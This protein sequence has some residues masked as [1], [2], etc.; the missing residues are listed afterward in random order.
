MAGKKLIYQ[1]PVTGF[2]IDRIKPGLERHP[3]RLNV[4][5]L[6]FIEVLIRYERPII[7]YLTFFIWIRF[8]LR[9]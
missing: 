2:Y 3:R 9:N 5:I 7:W 1:V 4:S 6:K 8:L